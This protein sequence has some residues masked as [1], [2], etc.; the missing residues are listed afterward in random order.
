MVFVCNDRVEK[1][2]KNDNYRQSVSVH[3][4]MGMGKNSV[5]VHARDRDGYE[6][7][8]RATFEKLLCK[9]RLCRWMKKKVTS[10]IIKMNTK[11]EKFILNENIR[12]GSAKKKGHNSYE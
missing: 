4:M 1:H 5:Q 7:A 6:C 12:R 3:R 11:Y 8:V 2:A 10:I 9:T